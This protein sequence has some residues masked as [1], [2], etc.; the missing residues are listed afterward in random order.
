MEVKLLQVYNSLLIQDTSNM[1]D[2]EKASRVKTLQWMQKK[3]MALM[4][5]HEVYIALSEIVL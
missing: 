3:I 1:T 2:E 5:K 4:R